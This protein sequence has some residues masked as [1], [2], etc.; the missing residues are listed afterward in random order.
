ML[1]RQLLRGLVIL[2]AAIG[3]GIGG[4]VLAAPNS[5]V[6]PLPPAILGFT[7]DARTITVE[8]I[9]SGAAQIALSWQ[10]V[11]LTDD[12]SL[13]LF[14]LVVSDWA[15]LTDQNLPPV[16]SARLVVQPS[17]DFAPPTYRLAIFDRQG[18]LISQQI[19][20]LPYDTMSPLPTPQIVSFEATV[21]GVDFVDLG[22]NRARIPVI[23]R[24]RGRVPT[25]N[26]VFEQLLPDGRAI[27]VEL[28][29]LSRWIP[30]SGEGVVAPILP[31]NDA[32]NIQ[33]RLRVVDLADGTVYAEQV[34]TLP[35]I[36]GG[37]P[38]PTVEVPAQP[39]PPV[40]LASPTPSN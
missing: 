29:R 1:L 25:A 37:A 2:V 31:S 20:T 35:I 27:S 13:R 14:A 39:P 33:L 40:V 12:F 3:I 6:D 15:P 19:V 4:L 11:G 24:V 10:T 34:I 28:P 30:S 32:L 17:L 18:R 5:Q 36:R 22:Q 23:W 8:A 38:L 7:S 9:E 16:G 21:G 26:L